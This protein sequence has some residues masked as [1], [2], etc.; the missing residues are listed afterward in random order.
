MGRMGVWLEFRV[1]FYSGHIS[2]WGLENLH[3]DHPNEY[4]TTDAPGTRFKGNEILGM[5]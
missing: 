4:R 5:S 3:R 1:S 2:R